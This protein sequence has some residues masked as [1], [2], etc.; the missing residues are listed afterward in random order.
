MAIRALAEGRTLGHRRRHP[1]RDVAWQVTAQHAV[2]QLV[3]AAWI[4]TARESSEKRLSFLLAR[5]GA[6][7][8]EH[9]IETAPIGADACGYPHDVTHRRMKRLYAGLVALRAR[10]GFVDRSRVVHRCQLPDQACAQRERLRIVGW[11]RF[12]TEACKLRGKQGP[13]G[14]TQGHA[15]GSSRKRLVEQVERLDRL[16]VERRAPRVVHLREQR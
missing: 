12:P 3:G 15:L 13:R 2:E 11:S 1:R 5:G 4:A 10:K 14:L 8:G 9:G 7:R 16:L 6:E